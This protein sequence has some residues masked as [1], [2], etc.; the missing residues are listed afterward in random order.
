[1]R[2]PVCLFALL[3]TAAVWAAVLLSPPQPSISEKAEGR[4]VTLRGTVE[5][6]E[7][8]V[9]DPGG[10]QYIRLSL[11]DAFSSLKSRRKGPLRSAEETKYC[12]P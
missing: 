10:E 9:Q 1:M 4:Y 12:A 2:R 8:A 3:F 7:Y 5:E 11:K 6:K